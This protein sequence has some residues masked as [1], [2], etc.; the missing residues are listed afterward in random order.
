[1]QKQDIMKFLNSLKNLF[2]VGIYLLLTA[3]ILECVAVGISR[4]ISIP[5]EIP[6]GWKEA[7]TGILLILCIT[8]M[9]WFNKTL[10]LAAI[11]LAGGENKLTTTGPFNY[12]RH[13]LYTTLILTLP[14][15]LIIW[16]EDV[17]FAVPWI[18]ICICATLLIPIEEKGLVSIFGNEY[19]TYKKFV[20][21]LIPYKGA[22]GE[23]FR[24]Y[25]RDIKH[26]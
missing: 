2:G 14:T 16:F 7:L 9:M 22:G 20:P 19:R 26:T 10:D 24:A 4:Y 18:L 6:S 21:A 8:G 5:V 17:L 11:H 1:M 12:V 3:I 23:K 13:P 25:C 15:I